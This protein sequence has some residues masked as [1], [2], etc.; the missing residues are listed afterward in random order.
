AT[1][2]PSTTSTDTP[3]GTSTGTNTPTGTATSTHTNTP[4]VSVT[5]VPCNGAY[6]YL[7]PHSASDPPNGGTVQTG[8]QFSLDMSVSTGGFTLTAQQAYLTFTYQLLDNVN[9][10]SGSCVLTNNVTP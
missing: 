10:T 6:H 8:V 5:P 4:T 9:A 7:L 3:T 2:T 1:D